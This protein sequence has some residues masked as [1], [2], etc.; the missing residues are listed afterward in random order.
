MKETVTPRSSSSL[1]GSY[2]GAR[3]SVRLSTSSGSE[4]FWIA[5]DTTRS[6]P[7]SSVVMK[8][9]GCIGEALIHGCE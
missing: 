6:V 7:S 9:T 5:N 3:W 1:S 4:G 2:L 8:E